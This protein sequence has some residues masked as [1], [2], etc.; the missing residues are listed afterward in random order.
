[1]K[2]LATFDDFN[3]NIF[4]DCLYS[5]SPKEIVSNETYYIE[6]AL[7]TFTSTTTGLLFKQT[8]EEELPANESNKRQKKSTSVFNI[9][10]KYSLQWQSDS[11]VTEV[12]KHGNTTV[13]QNK[14]VLYI[15]IPSSVLTKLKASV[16]NEKWQSYPKTSHFDR[17]KNENEKIISDIIANSYGQYRIMKFKKSELCGHIVS[18]IYS[19]FSMFI[20]NTNKYFAT[21]DM[22]IS[23]SEEKVSYGIL[24]QTGQNYIFQSNGYNNAD[25]KMKNT[26][27]MAVSTMI[28]EKLR[29]NKYVDTIMV[30]Y[31]FGDHYPF[32]NIKVELKPFSQPKSTPKN[33]KNLEDIIF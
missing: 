1:M 29:C 22:Y 20:E 12:K 21:V 25:F 32:M 13:K 33:S 7:G 23:C 28:K 31:S 2:L 30:R 5:L 26:I 19:H 8:R 11:I 14:K 4:K 16:E 24:H 18:S 6:I 27:F 3:E 17:Q 9:C 15:I 10:S